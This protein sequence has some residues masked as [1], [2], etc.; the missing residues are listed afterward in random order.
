MDEKAGGVT[1][2]GLKACDRCRAAVKALAAAG[3][4]V[5]L[6]DVRVEPLDDSVRARFL[7][8]FGEA[9]LNRQS[10]T[11]RALP[12]DARSQS[13]AALLADH[14]A[15]MKRPVIEAGQALHLGWDAGVKDA[16]GL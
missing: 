9:L 4:Q 6:V 1:V 11:W 13:P 16:L 7:A 10:T 14:P 2:Y 3:H 15:L 8:H 12:E 5:R